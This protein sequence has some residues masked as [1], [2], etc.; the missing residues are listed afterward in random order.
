MEY[1]VKTRQ[2]SKVYK[3]QYAV[4]NVDMNIVRGDI[5]GFVGENGAGKTTIIRLLTGL[6]NVSSGTYEL[7]G[8][9]CKDANISTSRRKMSAV[10]ESPSLFLNL[11]AYDNLLLQCKQLGIKD[12]S[13][14]NSTLE[15][16]GLSYLKSEKKTVKDF[17][18][19]MRQRLGIA[20][21]LIGNPEF[22]ILDEPMNGLDPEGILE[23]R[24]LILKL[25]RE[26]NI[27]FLIS[28]HI[29]TELAKVATKYG[30]IHHGKLIQE[31]R[32]TDLAEASK[33]CLEIIVDDNE[34]AARVLEELK[35]TNYKK[36]GTKMLRIYEEV[37]IVK[38]VKALDAVGVDIE[39]ISN[40]DENIEEYYLKLIGGRHND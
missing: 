7:F 21:A 36:I 4:D 32:A 17:S 2:I 11:S 29:L 5:Y 28:S 16:V 9:D 39:K 20:V 30:F 8:V 3:N 14:I 38:L 34:K 37:K 12:L 15:T 33:K 26:M 18:L 27:T 35:I 40:K 1:I 25:N 24:E 23:V 13:I 31:I 19:G 10:V 22:I 6:A